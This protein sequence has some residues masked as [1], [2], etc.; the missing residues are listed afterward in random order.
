M[1]KTFCR[2]KKP[3]GLARA[4]KSKTKDE[5][6]IRIR[7]TAHLFRYGPELETRQFFDEKEKKTRRT[8]TNEKK[9]NK[10]WPNEKCYYNQRPSPETSNYNNCI[11]ILLLFFQFFFFLFNSFSIEKQ[12]EKQPDRAHFMIQT[13]C[14]FSVL[15]IFFPSILFLFCIQFCYQRHQ[16]MHSRRKLISINEEKKNRNKKFTGKPT[17]RTTHLA[18]WFQQE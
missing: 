4:Q 5:Y 12:H 16:M 17:E 10:N 18:Y 15:T 8:T 7:K 14:F 6:R 3:F 1:L 11:H 9:K 13:T 2:K